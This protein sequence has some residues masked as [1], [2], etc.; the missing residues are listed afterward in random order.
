LSFPW[1]KF[2]ALGRRRVAAHGRYHSCEL[3]IVDQ[4]SQGN[5]AA[6][7]AGNLRRLEAILDSFF[8]V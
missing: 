6:L 7:V 8:T 5:F 4:E 3:A 1:S 2:L